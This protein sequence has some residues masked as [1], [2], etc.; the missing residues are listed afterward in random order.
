MTAIAP[1]FFLTGQFHFGREN[2]FLRHSSNGV[3]AKGSVLKVIK[4]YQDITNTYVNFVTKRR[5]TWMK[6]C[7]G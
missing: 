7:H 2:L 6:I 3:V 1:K 4:L 5:K